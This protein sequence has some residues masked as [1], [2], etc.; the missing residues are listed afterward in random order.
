MYHISPHV[1]WR[2]EKEPREK[3]INKVEIKSKGIFSRFV[4]HH[5][6]LF[7]KPWWSQ[8]APR[9]RRHAWEGAGT[10]LFFEEKLPTTFLNVQRNVTYT[11]TET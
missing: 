1:L 10:A 6:L 7:S 3:R 8:E 11:A 2:T 5:L 9:D 4:S